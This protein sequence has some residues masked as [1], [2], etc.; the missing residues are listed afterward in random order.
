ML[1]WPATDRY[2]N[3]AEIPAFLALVQR[4]ERAWWRI[5]LTVL[6]GAVG[7]FLVGLLGMPIAAGL[8]MGLLAAMGEPATFGRA[9]DIALS[10]GGTDTS[11]S[12]AAEGVRIVTLGVLFAGLALTLLL[13]LA[14]VNR[15]PMRS[16]ITAAPRFRWRL[17]LLGLTLYAGVLAV[18]LGVSV[19]SGD[20][21]LRPPLFTPGEPLDARLLYAGVVLLAIPL[22]AAFEEILCRGWMMQL[23]GAF[24]RNLIVL[25]LVNGAI[26]SGLH[27]DPDPGRFVARLASG[28]AFSWAALRLGGLEFAIGAHAA[29]NLMIALFAQTITANLSDTTPASAVEIAI[30]LAA[31]VALMGLAELTLRWAPL[32]QWSGAGLTASAAAAPRPSA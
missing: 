15:R 26:F 32:R 3:L 17:M 28:V 7:F 18:V 31:A 23:T 10:T 5:V 21:S 22:A 4:K 11:G 24:S 25:L 13:T 6:L 19:L 2:L 29:N 1:T 16:W 8:G 9:L 12:L 20:D 27:L 14:A 30:E